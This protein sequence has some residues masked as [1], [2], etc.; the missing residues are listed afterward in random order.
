MYDGAAEVAKVLDV[1]VSDG[2]DQESLVAFIDRLVA[3]GRVGAETRAARTR[4]AGEV[5]AGEAPAGLR[6]LALSLNTPVPPR[7]RRPSDEPET[8]AS[9][10]SEEG[11]V[12]LSGASDDELVDALGVLVGRGMRIVVTATDA[13]VPRALRTRFPSS[14]AARTV[15]RL[16]SLD[17]AELRRLRRLLATSTPERR[18]R[19]RQELPGPDALPDPDD[20][21]GCSAR[22]LRTVAGS[23]S[24]EAR[25]IPS[26]LRDLDAERRAAV[27]SVGRCVGRTVGA[28]NASPHADWLRPVVYRLVHNVHRSE[29][30]QLQS[31]AAQQ[32]DGLERFATSPE[33]VE[34]GP[35]PDDAVEI[36][37]EYLYF[38]SE[39]GR[40]RTY[41]RPQAQRDAQPVLSRFRVGGATPQSI[42]QIGAVVAHLDLAARRREIDRLCRELEAPTPQGLQ[43][44]GELTVALDAAAAAARSVGALR[45][46]VLFLQH[47]SPVVVPDLPAAE[48]VARAI[49]DYDE[50]GDPA[51]AADELDR[52]ADELAGRVPATAMSPEHERAVAALRAR[53][54][55]AYVEVLEDLVAARRDAA[56]QHACDELLDRLRADAPTLARAWVADDRSRNSGYGLLCCLPANAL[57]AELPP[58]DGADLVVVLGAGGL[59]ADALLLS[60]VAPRMVAVV[61]DESRA[62]SGTTL[63]EVLNQASARFLRGTGTAGEPATPA[64][65]NGDPVAIPAQNSTRG[66]G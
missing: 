20:I 48:R 28:L 57:L 6:R 53:D 40:R 34:A 38:L 1:R 31:L 21:A 32:R 60:A 39:G 54:A 25:L 9:V 29:F 47:G 14:L 36:L 61:G 5:R 51:E 26:L 15:D 17:P 16:P 43:E 7:P 13:G 37:R 58:A 4:I 64:T 19:G 3:T 46:D 42:A 33:V 59:P 50:H 11:L 44:L 24:E 45:H 66:T 41:F 52:L 65:A 23:D 10:L 56:D 30:D 62:T 22:A 49:V 2:L 12:V 27:T 18:V 55:D 63:L 35:I 8:L